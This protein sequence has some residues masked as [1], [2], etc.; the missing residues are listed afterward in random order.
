M[1]NGE[2][3][4]GRA[5]F[6][7]TL[8]LFLAGFFI[9]YKVVPVRVDGYQFREVMRK[10]ARNAVVHRNDSVV[11]ER[12]LDEARSM[13]I[14]LRAGDL[15]ISRTTVEVS[16]SARYEKPIDLKVGTYVY[17]FNETQKAPLF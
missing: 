17:K 13:D 14:P 9:L 1:R 16:I 15:K 2:R 11:V 7:F 4:N 8:C 12:L 10:E 6:F 5:G 3:G